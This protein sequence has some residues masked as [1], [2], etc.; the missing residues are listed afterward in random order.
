VK[1]VHPHFTMEEIS[2]AEDIFPV[3]HDLFRRQEA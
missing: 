2:G 1:A 3:F